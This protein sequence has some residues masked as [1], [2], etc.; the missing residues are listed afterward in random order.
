MVGAD[1][2]R[3]RIEAYA[4]PH[5]GVEVVWAKRGYTLYGRHTGGPVARLVP[6]E[7]EDRVQVLWW[8]RGAWGTLGDFGPVILPLGPT[9]GFVATEGFFWINA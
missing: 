3:A 6:S 8:H 9:L 7:E 5:G 2:L 1:A 4:W